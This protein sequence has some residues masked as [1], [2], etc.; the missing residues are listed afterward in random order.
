M[1]V[2]SIGADLTDEG[3]SMEQ[4][5]ILAAG[6]GE[7]LVD[8]LPYPKPLQRVNGVPLIERVLRGLE[9]AGVER[10]GIVVGHLGETLQR[11][12]RAQRFELE[13]RFVENDEFRK[14][15]GT[16]LLKARAL[17]T[18]PTFLL[19]SDHL[20]SADLL[21]RVRAYPLAETEA[22][23]GIDFKVADCFDLPDA[24]KV[25]IRGD[26]VLQ[27]GKELRRY[28]ALDTGVFRI[29]PAVIEALER[30]DGPSG[31]SLSQGIAELARTGRMRVVDVEDAAWVDIDTPAMLAHAETLLHVH[32]RALRPRG[33]T[34]AARL[35]AE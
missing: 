10:V 18:G 31:C 15:N 4:A 11:A 3:L 26:R 9:R 5:I 25:A 6:R 13:L 17:V 22:V 14:P 12:L 32:G 2:R 28:D 24:T 33:G 7:R 1:R 16:S 23:L 34:A 27:I 20:W 21:E 29:T 35:S 30:V 8:G 19:M